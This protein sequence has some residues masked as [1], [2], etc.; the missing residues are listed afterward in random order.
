MV[1]KACIYCLALDRNSLLT[2]AL[3][4]TVGRALGPAPCLRLALL[5]GLGGCGG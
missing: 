2:P 5:G 1:H 3:E 4:E